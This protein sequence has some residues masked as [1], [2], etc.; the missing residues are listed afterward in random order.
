MRVVAGEARGRRL[1]APAGRV[2][3]PTSDRVREAIFDTL[4]CITDLDGAVVVDLFAGSGA[5]GVEALSRRAGSVTFVEL[6]RAALDAIRANLEVVGAVVGAGGRAAVVRADA[7]AWAA[8]RPPAAR[9]DLVLADPPYRFDRWS[10]LAGAL[11]AWAG[12]VV[13][14]S[15][16]ELDLGPSWQ[17]LRVR[18]YGATVVTVARPDPSP[19]TRTQPKGGT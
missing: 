10:D 11:A 6:D 17:T 19:G 16:A 14:E 3:R 13:L 5:L 9:A 12:L 7:L 2:T 15:G 1:R 18:C 4:S 8:G